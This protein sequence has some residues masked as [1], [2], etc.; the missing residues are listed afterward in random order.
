MADTRAAIQRWRSGHEAAARRQL[1]LLAAEGPHPAQAVAEAL[2]AIN[3][4]E[5]TGEWP[6]PRDAVSEAAVAMVRRRWAR[7][8]TRAR[9]AARS[10]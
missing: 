6:G 7:I 8:Q 2:A 4:L 3:A 10:R 1:E 9:A 5:A